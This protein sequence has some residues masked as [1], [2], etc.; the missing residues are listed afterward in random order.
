L[1]NTVEAYYELR[2]T[3][4]KNWAPNTLSMY[5][6]H[7]EP[8]QIDAKFGYVGAVLSTLVMDMPV[9]GGHE[10]GER[11]CWGLRLRRRGLEGV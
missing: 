10:G 9:L 6:G 2:L 7:D 5:S 11:W 3:I 4:Q 1:N 8:F